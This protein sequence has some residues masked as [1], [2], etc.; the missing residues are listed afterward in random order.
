MSEYDY[1]F[2]VIVVGDG[3]VGKTAITI[4]FAEGR[5]EEHYKMTIGVDFAIKLIEIAGYKVKLQV[6]DTGGQERFSY[7]RPLYYKGA[8]AAL[9]IFDLTNRES[10]DNLPKWFQEVADNCGPIPLMLVGNKSDLPDRAVESS[11]AQTLSQK[12][13]INYFEASA[14]NGKNI[15][16]LFLQLGELLLHAKVP[17]IAA[18]P[19]PVV[20]EVE[21]PTTPISPALTPPPTVPT[22]SPPPTVPTISSTPEPPTFTP[23]TVPATPTITPGL[24]G[25]PSLDE[26]LKILEGTEEPTTEP[27]DLSSLPPQPVEIIPPMPRPV[28]I[29][30]PPMPKPIEITPPMPKPI[31]ITPPMPKPVEMTPPTPKPI[32]ITPPTLKPIDLTPPPMKPIDVT[33][34]IKLPPPIETKPPTPEP[35]PLDTKPPI[36]E[37]PTTFIPF[38]TASATPSTSSEPTGAS[39][40]FVPFT[41]G[42]PTT[43][44]RPSTPSAPSGS[45]G[46][47]WIDFMKD[48]PKVEEKKASFT[49]FVTTIEEPEEIILEV[50]PKEKEEKKVK[51]V[52]CPGCHRKI[53][54]AWK[55]CTYCGATLN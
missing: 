20:S 2:K 31:E 13:G 10:Y 25:S 21:T 27:P 3:A 4:R 44:P 36:P 51:E 52:E 32:D 46:T 16:Q 39:P 11:E 14:K 24:D 35:A 5:F 17:A 28:E 8:M 53:S 7:I 23:P 6:W 15:N 48:A 54:T 55:F 50:V 40:V 19:A 47:T 34:P 37:T 42:G 45:T 33:P 43:T 30:P 29:T 22:I 9:A 1:L 18:A 26:A 38:S 12:M 41:L 49:P